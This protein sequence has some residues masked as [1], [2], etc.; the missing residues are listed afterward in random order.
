M[1]LNPGET[2]NILFHFTIVVPGG[3][4]PAFYL[5]QKMINKGKS[6]GELE[7]Y[8]IKQNIRKMKRYLT[9]PGSIP[10]NRTCRKNIEPPEI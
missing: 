6:L 8:D 3:M 10:L 4:E 2:K 5:K 9:A 1:K 7:E